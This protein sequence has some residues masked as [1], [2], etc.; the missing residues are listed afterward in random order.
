MTTRTK[1]MCTSK[2]HS[3]QLV[4]KARNFH[5]LQWIKLRH[6]RWDMGSWLIR[7]RWNHYDRMR[8][9]GLI[10]WIFA[11]TTRFVYLVCPSSNWS[12]T[13]TQSLYF[14]SSFIKTGI[15]IIS[16]L[17][18]VASECLCANIWFHTGEF[19]KIL[20]QNP[21]YEHLVTILNLAHL[22]IW[23]PNNFVKVTTFNIFLWTVFI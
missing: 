13:S 8:E 21:R 17:M 5:P 22:I 10:C 20:N 7:S 6:Y 1:I 14:F 23:Y 15:V 18:A 11:T 3:C 9:R 2:P 16:D 4:T 12:K 19:G